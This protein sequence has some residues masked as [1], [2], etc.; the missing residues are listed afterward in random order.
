VKVQTKKL[1]KG[2]PQEF[3]DNIQ[4][5]TSDQLKGEIVRLQ[6]QAQENEAFKESEKYVKEKETFDAAR[7]R[8]N[9]VAGPVRETAVSIRNKTKLLVERMREKGS[10]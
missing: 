5:M 4:A 9:E 7:S 10:I 1:P 3:V 8:F 2:V 6:V